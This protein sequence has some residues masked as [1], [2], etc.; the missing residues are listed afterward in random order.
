MTTGDDGSVRTR[1]RAV[2]IGIAVIAVVAVVVALIAFLPR[3]TA[4]TASPT[5]SATNGTASA[6]DGAASAD[7]S[8]SPV[9]TGTIPTESAVP[10]DSEAPVAPGVTAAVADFEAVE[11]EAKMPGEVAGPSIRF[12]I[13]ITNSTDAPVSLASALVNVYYGPSQTPSQDMSNPGVKE[14]PAEIPAGASV[15]G[16]LVFDVPEADRDL[17][18]ITLDYQPGEPVVAFQ[19][20]FPA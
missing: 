18:L 17:L 6:T 14:L 7:P 10:I 5:G 4:P 8:S 15:D 2:W 9:A 12:T 11:S 19:G 16:V 13:T 20:S 1:S 3:A